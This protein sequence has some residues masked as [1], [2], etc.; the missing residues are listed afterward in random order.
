MPFQWDFGNIT[1]ISGNTLPPKIKCFVSDFF[2][3]LFQNNLSTPIQQASWQNAEVAMDSESTFSFKLYTH[4][5]ISE[6]DKI[7]KCSI[8]K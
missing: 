5:L 7:L 8:L 3:F 4:L 2:F 1:I 6:N